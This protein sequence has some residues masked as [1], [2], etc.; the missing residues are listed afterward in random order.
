MATLAELWEEPRDITQ[1]AKRPGGVYV[2]MAH[3]SYQ[4]AVDHA[5]GA[6]H[7]TADDIVSDDWSKADAP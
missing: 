7:V 5:Q 1:V 4:Q 6:Q 2:S 3:K